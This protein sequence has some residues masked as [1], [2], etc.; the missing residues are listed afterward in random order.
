M[1]PALLCHGSCA[2]QS[3]ECVSSNTV[4]RYIHFPGTP[5]LNPLASY[6]GLLNVH[7]CVC[8]LLSVCPYFQNPSFVVMTHTWCDLVLLKH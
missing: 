1:T 6:K 2:S 4:P 3:T 8:F 5:S 7:F